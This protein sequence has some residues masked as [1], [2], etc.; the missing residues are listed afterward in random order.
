MHPSIWSSSILRRPSR[1]V[2]QEFA[3]V[4]QAT[5]WRN[6]LNGRLGRT[7]PLWSLLGRFGDEDDDAVLRAMRD[8]GIEDPSTA[9]RKVRRR[10]RNCAQECRQ[11]RVGQTRPVTANRVVECV[12]SVYRYA[13]TCGLID[14]GFNPVKNAASCGR[15][16][17]LISTVQQIS[18]GRPES[19]AAIAHG[20]M[21]SPKSSKTNA[22][23]PDRH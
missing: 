13:A 12:S 1:F 11:R 3:L 16:I 19:R 18:T 6:V 2:F 20:K 23:N 10:P 21:C 22:Q 4:E 5:V 14:R 17:L 9:M 8:V 15:P 7:D